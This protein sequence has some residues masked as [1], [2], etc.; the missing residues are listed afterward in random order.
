MALARSI[1]EMAF[2]SALSASPPWHIVQA[3]LLILK[4]PFPKGDH[5]DVTFPLGG[6]MLHIAMHNGLHIP[7]SSHEFSRVKITTPSE[8]DLQRRSEMWA[9]T[10]VLYQ[11]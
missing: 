4:W 8:A 11:R 9:L 3:F 2:L 7:L 5:P 10:M 6:M 1:I